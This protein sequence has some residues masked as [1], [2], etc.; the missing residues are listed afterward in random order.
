MQGRNRPGKPAQGP[1]PTPRAKNADAGGLAFVSGAPL[2]AQQ[3]PQVLGDDFGAQV[4]EVFF[5]LTQ[6][7]L[8]PH[9]VVFAVVKVFIL[10][11]C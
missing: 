1:V 11:E 4:A 8:V 9:A 5:F 7:Q 10:V 2:V 3:R 6:G